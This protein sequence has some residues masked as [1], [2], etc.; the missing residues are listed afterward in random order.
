MTDVNTLDIR[1]KCQE[2]CFFLRLRLK[3][4]TVSSIYFNHACFRMLLKVP[5]AG[6]SL[7]FPG[8]EPRSHFISN[9]SL[10]WNRWHE[11]RATHGQ[12]SIPSLSNMVRSI[13]HPFRQPHRQRT[14]SVWVFLSM[15]VNRQVVYLRTDC[16]SALSA[17]KR[18]L[19]AFGPE[20]SQSG[21]DQGHFRRSGQTKAACD[22][23]P[24]AVVYH[25]QLPTLVAFGFS[26]GRPF[27][28]A[29]KLPSI[30]PC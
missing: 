28:A 12:R 7:G 11:K 23:N 18:C 30:N 13:F 4:F 2:S 20:S 27:F 29:A 21:F 22:R 10:R 3:E 19:D 15:C 25:H 1:G 24:L 17:I 16:R 6:S 9:S 14:P 8:I 26:D 5:S